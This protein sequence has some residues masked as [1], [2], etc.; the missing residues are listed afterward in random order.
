MRLFDSIATTRFYPFSPAIIQ[1]YDRALLQL[2]QKIIQTI[3]RRQN[4]KTQFEVV[5]ERIHRATQTLQFT[6]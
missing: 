2:K 6:S 3:K 4:S 1:Y 5:V